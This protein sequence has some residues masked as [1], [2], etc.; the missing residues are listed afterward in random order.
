MRGRGRAWVTARLLC[1]AATLALAAT[2][3]AQ[4]PPPADLDP[5]APLD[6]MPDLGVAWPE[7]DADPDEA[8]VGTGEPEA[9]PAADPAEQRPYTVAVEGL[10][11]LAGREQ[12]VDSFED[13]SALHEYRDE[14]ANAAQIDRRSRADA[15]LLAELLRGQGYYDAVVVP[16]IETTPEALQVVLEAEPGEQYR[17]VSVELP[18]LAAAGEQAAELRKAFA[19]EPG[20]PVIATDVLAAGV[21]LKVALGEEGFALAEV[22]E[23]Q[24]ELDHE[25][26][27][28]NLVLPVEP[29]PVARF[30]AIRVSGRPPFP[31]RHV[32][33][34][35]RFEPGETFQRSKVDDL[36]RALV[37]TGLISSAEIRVVSAA[38]GRT[39][40][41]AVQLEPA[42]MRTIA[43]E[44][45]YGTGEGLRAE[46]S[47]QH[48]NFVNPE[49]ALTLRGVV[50]TREQV[51]AVE[52]RRSN[53]R[54]RDQVLTLHALASKIDRDA[55]EARTILLGA[56]IERQSNIIWQKKWTWGVGTEF[57]A[58]DERGVF[59]DPTNKET[60]T[61]LIAALPAHIRYDG[62][63]D[64][65][66]PT[67]GFRLG[68]RISPE[69]SAR[70]GGF[71]YGRAQ[72][73]G[74]AY[75][76]VGERT[77]L[78]GRVRLGTIIGAKSSALAP[79]RRFYS[80]GGGSV[81]GYGYQQLG[82]RDADGD[83]IGGRGLA[84]FALE[85][86]VRLSVLGGNFG[87]VPFLD[88]GTLSTDVMPDF[89]DWQFGAGLGVRYYSS[90]GPIRVDVGTP[91][92]RRE[93]DPRI[94]VTVSLGQAF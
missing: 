57:I 85:A 37:A 5:S 36:R 15:E 63:N 38:D 13:Q 59:A 47:W 79:S 49:G 92:N 26:R 62:S 24:V 52:F 7:M 51:A 11:Q 18:G 71:A 81:R 20:D 48:R 76:P 68:G 9:A 27:R 39:V 34:I 42:P 89:N 41:L 2:A 50:G 23:Q 84:E 61:F 64:L 53:F 88:G 83:P 16:R 31:A 72:I 56:G 54:Q 60:R 43:G 1:A 94:A 32:A 19:V 22:G 67:E 69:Y 44:L 35:A 46:A 10:D 4:A 91:L 80:G 58:T 93:G 90:F 77:V 73:D 86:R 70:E 25:T 82:P 14:R 55:F 65:L 6:P 45:G 28:A 78:A 8:A 87:I 30:G 12:L 33:E 21:A 3:A 74:S 40:D 75:Y 17:F 66:D 29:G